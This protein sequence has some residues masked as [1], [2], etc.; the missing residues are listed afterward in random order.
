MKYLGLILLAPLTVLAQSKDSDT[1][2]EI[3]TRFKDPERFSEA[4]HV[5]TAVYQYPHRPVKLAFIKVSPV[6]QKALKKNAPLQHL[7]TL[8]IINTDERMLVNAHELAD[9]HGFFYLVNKNGTITRRVHQMFV[10]PIEV[11]TEMYEPPANYVAI[12]T[13]K[14]VSP[15][16]PDFG[17]I[18]Q[19]GLRF[20]QTNAKWTADLLNDAEASSAV[21]TTLSANA[22]LDWRESFRLGATFQYESSSHRFAGGSAQYKNPSFG[23][24]IQSPPS[25]WGGGPWRV[26]AQLRMGPFATLQVPDQGGRPSNIKLRTT[27]LQLDWQYLSSNS[28]GEWSLGVAVQRDYP[29]IRRQENASFLESDARTNDQAGLFFTQGFAW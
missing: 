1:I 25:Y 4:R 21:S 14:N 27:T 10:E 7:D 12:T 2:N 5:N 8:T 16:D 24:L 6:V 15:N 26:G 13:P 9:E 28:W 18:P 29:K 17:W 23:L 20:G 3:G 22:L 19:L 11:V